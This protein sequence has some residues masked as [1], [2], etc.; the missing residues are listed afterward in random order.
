MQQ[1]TPA[2]ALQW[3]NLLIAGPTFC[4]HDEIKAKEQQPQL[5]LQKPSSLLYHCLRHAL[6]ACRQPLIASA[7]I[8]TQTGQD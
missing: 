6:S 1:P 2:S 7:G 8:H 5:C 3:N 4:I